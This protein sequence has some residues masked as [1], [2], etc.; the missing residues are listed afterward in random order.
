MIQNK[1]IFVIS[2][3]I[4]GDKASLTY[5]KPCKGFEVWLLLHFLGYRYLAEDLRPKL[6]RKKHFIRNMNGSS[7][8][9]FQ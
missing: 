7:W 3:N 6:H 2:T 1:I 9:F 4:F 8:S 5:T